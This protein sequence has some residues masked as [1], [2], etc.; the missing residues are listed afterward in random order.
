MIKEYLDKK[1]KTVKYKILDVWTK[2]DRIWDQI[3]SER[4]ENKSKKY[5]HKDTWK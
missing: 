1:L 4:K 3:A 2:E 5:S